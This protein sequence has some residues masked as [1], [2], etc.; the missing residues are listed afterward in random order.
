M[1]LTRNRVLQFCTKTKQNI[2]SA[3]YIGSIIGKS[4]VNSVNSYKTIHF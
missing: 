1:A 3:T 2:N 4:D